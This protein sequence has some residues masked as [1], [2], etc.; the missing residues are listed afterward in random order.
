MIA[1]ASFRPLKDCS[2]QILKNQLRARESWEKSFS[3]I[4]YFGEPERA[5][6]GPN[7][8][9]I[10]RVGNFPKIREMLLMAAT[11][12]DWGVLI[13]ADITLGQG[14]PMIEE[15]LHGYGALCAMSRRFE[16]EGDNINDGKMI[17]NGLDFFA[18]APSV[19]RLAVRMI[20]H[21]YR[22]GHCLFDTWLLGF[23]ASH[24][25][26]WLWDITECRI[27]FHPKHEDRHR[28]FNID[29]A[30]GKEQ[31]DAVR[32]PAVERRLKIKAIADATGTQPH[33]FFP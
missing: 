32:W 27:V 13:N 6:D 24:Y 26:D 3:H 31:V 14:L 30:A 22:I 20:P 28:I 7:V 9:F 2:P 23:M 8:T 17:D 21:D 33:H 29:H 5:L 15:K 10:Q 25:Y 12:K 19:W 11:L 16:F 4:I 1:V 18:A